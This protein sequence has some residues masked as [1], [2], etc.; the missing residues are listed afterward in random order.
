M[1]IDDGSGLIM[2]CI[3]LYIHNLM[4]FG[5]ITNWFTPLDDVSKYPGWE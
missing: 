1:F 5:P 2:V 3:Y 4:M